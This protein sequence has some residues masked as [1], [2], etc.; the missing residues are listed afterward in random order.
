MRKGTF[1]VVV[2]LF[3]VLTLAAVAQIVVAGG[4]GSRFPGPTTD[5]PL[6]SLTNPAAS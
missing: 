2:A 6:P 3:V 1:I 4:G 5:T